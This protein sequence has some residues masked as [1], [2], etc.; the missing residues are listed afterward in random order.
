MPKLSKKKQQQKLKREKL[1]TRRE[2]TLETRREKTL[3]TRREQ[4][5]QT[6]RDQTL[7]TRRDQTLQT[8]KR[9]TSVSTGKPNN[10]Y[11]KMVKLLDK[12]GLT[13][14][15]VLD[16]LHTLPVSWEQYYMS[17]PKE[18]EQYMMDKLGDNS[19]LNKH[20]GMKK[21]KKTKRKSKGRR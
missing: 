3:Q 17:F 9:N 19:L 15:D 20:R 1:Q 5:L 6:R 8:R 16:I 10:K 7:Q 11:T 21:A 14:Y 2:Q 4:T 13:P 18:T 12:V